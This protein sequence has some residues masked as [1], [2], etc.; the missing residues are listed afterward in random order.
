MTPIPGD[1]V[2]YASNIPFQYSKIEGRHTEF[3]GN[4]IGTVYMAVKRYHE[5]LIRQGRNKPNMSSDSINFGPHN[6]NENC[7]KFEQVILA[8]TS[9]SSQFIYHT[10]G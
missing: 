1:S 7:S 5:F 9:D 2:I 8:N 10:R 6:T 4:L 3:I